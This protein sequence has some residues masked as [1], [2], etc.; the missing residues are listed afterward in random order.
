M[1]LLLLPKICFSY[2]TQVIK[3]IYLNTQNGVR[4]EF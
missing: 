4:G 3:N 2:K 1:I